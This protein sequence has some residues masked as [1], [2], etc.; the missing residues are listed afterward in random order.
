MKALILT[1]ILT[2]NNSYAKI[3][4]KI[5]ATINDHPIML[6][7]VIRLKKTISARKT[8]APDVYSNI[9]KSIKSITKHIIQQ[10][11]IYHKLEEIGYVV[12]DNQVENHIKQL[13]KRLSLSRKEL[14]KFLKQKNMYFYEYFETIREAI[15]FKLLTSKIISPYV[16]IS[17]QDVKNIFYQKKSNITSTKYDIID[18]SIDKKKINYSSF[19]KAIKSY[20]RNGILTKKYSSLKE[21]DINDISLESMN[22]KIKNIIKITG[23][24]EFSKV[25]YLNGKHHI[26]Y[27][28]NKKITAS[29]EFLSNKDKIK[30]K[31][32]ISSMKKAFKGWIKK[33]KLKH[34]I[35][36]FSSI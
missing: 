1:L 11:I 13:E 32:Y 29:E 33:E 25:V 6:S 12:N 36:F 27:V 31:L 4:D 5:V 8:I 21:T 34:H 23:K 28:K 18:Y 9:D 16:S 7:E 2:S 19:L 17:D 14:I 30:L 26:F 35:K 22:K 3:I 10:K 20:R 15:Q 24:N